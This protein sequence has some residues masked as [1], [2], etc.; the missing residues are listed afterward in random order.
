MFVPPPAG[1]GEA[2]AGGGGGDGGGAAAA[3]GG[4]GGPDDDDDDEIENP[5]PICLDNEDDATVDGKMNG[6]CYA[7][8][9]SYCGACNHGGLSV[10]VYIEAVK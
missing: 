10:Q 6:A 5:C 4:A 8:G 9:Q 1:W 7:C 2:A 3:G